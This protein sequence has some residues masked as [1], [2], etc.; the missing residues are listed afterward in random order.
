MFMKKFILV[1]ILSVFFLA[2]MK[3]QVTYEP[4][5][6]EVYTFLDRLASQHVISLNDE[7]KP[8]SRLKIGELLSDAKLK[9]NQLNEIQKEELSFYEEEYAHEIK[10]IPAF[11][12]MTIPE[13]WFLYKYS[14][15]LFNFRLS[16]FAGYGISATGDQ[17]GHTRWWG[18][19]TYGT[20]SDWFGAS[21]SYKDIGQYGG[22]VDDKKSFTPERGYFI[23][24]RTKDGIEFSD[25]TGGVNFNWKWGSVSLIK[26]NIQWGHGKFGQLIFSDKV[27][28][29]PQIRL[30]LNP[31]KWIRFYYMHG[32]L[33]SLV[34]DSSSTYYSHFE[35]SKP[36]VHK[37]YINKFVA[38][39][40][41]SITPIENLDI[42]IGNSAIYSGNLRP[43]MFIPFLYYKVMDHNTGR[44]DVDDANGQ[45]FFDV[46]SRNLEGF[47]FYS[48]LF[49]DG[50]SLTKTLNSN[51]S[52]N[53]LG[54]TFGVKKVNLL[55]DNL[56]VTF[57]Y[58]RLNPFVYEHKYQTEDY[59]HINFYL[60]DWL[61]QNADQIKL[62]LEYKPTRAINILCSIE[63]LRKAGLADISAE[64]TSGVQP[65]SFMWGT[66]RKDYA[67]TL[68]CTWTPYH[69]TY[70]NVY[71]KYSSI[72]DQ[73]KGRTPVYMLGDKNSFG[74]TLSYGL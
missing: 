28:S 37:Q 65:P 51:Y 63:K 40:L 73:Q 11:K 46:S 42:S 15:S 41:L 20:V 47:Q 74:V 39:N 19:S 32:W 49:I 26:D 68:A 3:A 38:A 45:I 12:G 69:D 9:L 58:T 34:I 35:S 52:D 53:E 7:V 72:T 21:F 13:R 1:I 70:A 59:K 60:G 30:Y 48:T 8:Y 57:E 6:S 16:P 61:G 23:N 54:Y 5:N 36:V 50:F 67:L 18:I 22:N 27:E 25:V 17:S 55:F 62:Q 14:D 4:I 33:N 29:Y 2:P 56:D 24:A 43:E 66:L 31:A 44:G 71:Y 64:Y 10:E